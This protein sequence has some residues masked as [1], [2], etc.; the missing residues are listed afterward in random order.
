MDAQKVG[1]DHGLL[2][3]KYRYWVLPGTLKS[4]MVDFAVLDGSGK[5]IGRESLHF[6]IQ[7]D[8]E[9]VLRWGGR[10]A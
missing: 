2:E 9:R 10:G 6:S 1:L 7:A 3:G 8:H 4:G 5:P